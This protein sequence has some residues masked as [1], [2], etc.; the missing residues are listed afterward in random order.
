[1]VD[2]FYEGGKA[3]F[4]SPEGPSPWGIA[5]SG[6]LCGLL[7]WVLV[8]VL[9]ATMSKQSLMSLP[10]LSRRFRKIYLPERCSYPPAR[11]TL[12]QKAVQV[13]QQADVRYTV[14]YARNMLTDVSLGT[15]V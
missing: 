2:Q 10:D 15:V 14:L 12:T 6:G 9:H 7:S 11:P 3:L 8:R 4:S 13:L 1:M 5:V